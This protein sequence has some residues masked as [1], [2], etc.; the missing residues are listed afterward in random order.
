MNFTNNFRNRIG[1]AGNV[2][3]AKMCWYICCHS[4][5]TIYTY[6]AY[7][8]I[9]C[10]HCSLIGHVAISSNF[11]NM[12]SI[13]FQRQR[14]RQRYQYASANTLS[15]SLQIALYHVGGWYMVICK[16]HVQNIWWPFC[17]LVLLFQ[18]LSSPANLSLWH[19]SA[20]L[21]HSHFLPFQIDWLNSL[22]IMLCCCCCCSGFGDPFSFYLSIFI[23]AATHKFS[24][25]SIETLTG[26]VIESDRDR[27]RDR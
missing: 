19:C 18:S 12:L 5:D 6:Q 2:S 26:S 4:I 23:F 7:R 22:Y 9:Q 13:S 21:N 17:I 14:Q 15:S 3:D 10:V 8:T 11:K 1:G 16:F 27:K 24:L 20:H 25:N